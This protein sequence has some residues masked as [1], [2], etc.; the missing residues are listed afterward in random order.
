MT[1]YTFQGYSISEYTGASPAIGSTFHIRSD[2]DAATDAITFT[3]TD[4]DS[5]LAGSRWGTYDT[6]QQTGTVTDASGTQLYSGTLR[7]GWR[8]T[9][10]LPDGSTVHVWDVWTGAT[11]G[12]PI[13]LISDGE[14]P[15]G[16]TF[17]IGAYDEATTAATWPSYSTIHTPTADPDLDNTVT[18]GTLSDS[19][20]GGAGDDTV[21]GGAG[22]DTVRLGDGND[23]FGDYAS[24]T[25][26]DLVYGGAG[27]DLLIGGPGNDTLY[28]DEGNDTLSGGTG[29]DCLFGG[30]GADEFIV[31]N[32][33]DH[34]TIDGGTE[35][36]SIWFSDYSGATYTVSVT[37][38]GTGTGSYSF[39]SGTDSGIFTSI[40]GI[41]GTS[42]NDTLNA[43]ADAG[44]VYLGGGAGNDVIIGGSGADT[45]EGGTGNDSITG[46]AGND[47]I[48]GG[49][50][51]N[52][53]A[54]GLGDDT[55]RVYD[56]NGAGTVIQGDGGTDT[57]EFYVDSG[58]TTGT[59]VVYS[60]AG[61]LSYWVWPAPFTLQGT[62]TGIEGIVGTQYADWIDAATYDNTTTST[63]ATGAG[64]DSVYGG[65]AAETVWLGE[66]NDI[67]YGNGGN[68][69]IYGEAGDDTLSGGS[70]ADTLDGGAGNDLFEVWAG[71]GSATITGGTGTDTLKF[72]GDA[73][74]GVTL[75]ST[76]PDTFS[77]SYGTASGI[78]SG[79]EAISGT[80]YGDTIDASAAGGAITLAG[81]AGNDVLTGGAGADRLDGGTG[82][83]LLTGGAGDDLFVS[84][85]GADTLGLADGSGQDT[86]SDFDL[87]GADSGHASDQLDVSDLTNKLGDP[88]NWSDVTVSDTAGDGTGD[89]ILLFPNGESL[90]LTGIS[91]AQ[92]SGKFALHA[93]GIPC[94]L[95]GTLIATP[96]GP[97][98]I[99]RLRAGDRVT[100]RDGAPETILWVGQRHVGAA[101]LRADPASRPIEI[102]I[103]AL[104]NTRPLRVSGQHGVLLRTEAGERLARARHLLLSGWDG[105]RQ[106]EDGRGARYYHLLLA[107]H[108]LVGAEGLWAESFWPGPIGCTSFG[109]GAL[110]DLLAACPAL[111]PALLGGARVESVYA[112]RVRPMLRRRDVMA[113]NCA[114]WAAA[115]RARHMPAQE[116]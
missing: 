63:Y 70:G 89:A 31:T 35:H 43:A 83:D 81:G 24:E 42:Y 49:K 37:Y 27:D 65:S 51:A 93:I 107:R 20:Y 61:A 13:G 87:T 96:A 1:V 6:T 5:T 48:S 104:G 55:F 36:D 26:N 62:A 78:V 8:A 44:G 29:S 16:V 103:G 14:L 40:E 74:T 95:S 71:N 111:A 34:E 39:S 80:S 41:G 7:V 84:G 106:I 72:L 73:G 100:T 19:L 94:F 88:V 52:T 50:G 18:G 112:P 99:E 92:V 98:P 23:V 11:D 54:G 67:A 114:R 115:T 45:L 22:N 32:G 17:Q 101:R 79:V 15:P 97:V 90:T 60:G 113:E 102:R 3:I 68:D 30:A 12:Y 69:A 77:Y 110:R 108:A 86:V 82:N 85:T 2:F 21:L 57:I 46:G 58:A 59:F 75:T 28:G 66:G 53:L 9:F 109:A 105:V 33:H 4:D 91:P 64:N 76:A 116:A 10:V 47:L 25:G 38:S 56:S